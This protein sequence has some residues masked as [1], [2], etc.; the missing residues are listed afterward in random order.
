[1]TY[2]TPRTDAAK[3]RRSNLVQKESGLFGFTIEE[4]IPLATAE[5]LE[6][7]AVHYRALAKDMLPWLM[8]NHEMELKFTRRYNEGPPATGSLGA[9]EGNR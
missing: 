7:E 4:V 1:M 5:Q 3:V 9:K 6:R 8:R 2:E